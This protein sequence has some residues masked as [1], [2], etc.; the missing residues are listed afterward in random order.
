MQ[1]DIDMLHRRRSDLED[2]ELEVMEKR[3]ALDAE[4]AALDAAIATLQDVAA[5]S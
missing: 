4:L 1:A 2:E 3:E 5:R